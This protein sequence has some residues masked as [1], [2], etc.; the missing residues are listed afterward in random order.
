MNVPAPTH[1]D[2]W[3]WLLISSAPDTP[4][5]TEFN[6]T[7][8]HVTETWHTVSK[9]PFHATLKPPQG[10]YFQSIWSLGFGI[11]I[12]PHTSE[13][14]LWA[15]LALWLPGSFLGFFTAWLNYLSAGESFMTSW[16][17]IVGLIPMGV[18]DYGESY[19]LF[20]VQDTVFGLAFSY[21]SRD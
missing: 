7:Y 15:V 13:W 12:Y 17:E 9:I 16:S 21:R 1:F 5:S 20:H 18:S 19:L 3:I 2:G 6:S 8:S 11:H 14:C 10:L 4:T